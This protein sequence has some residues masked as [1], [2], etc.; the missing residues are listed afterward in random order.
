MVGDEGMAWL[1]DV[2]EQ[3]D[4]ATKRLLTTVGGLTDRRVGEPSLLPGWSRGHVLSHMA[5]AAGAH[6]N[7]LQ[8][9]QGRDVPAY[10]SQEARDQ[11]IEEGAG[12]TVAEHLAELERSAARF[13]SAVAE[14]P[15]E[16]WD[17]PVTI[18]HLPPFPASQVLL[19][20]L[21]ETELHHV[22]L[23]AGYRVSDWPAS[24]R[25]GELPEPMRA[26]AADRMAWQ[27]Q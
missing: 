3:I 15:G 19:R 12:R 11:A 22:D 9:A 21:V 25:P 6:W 16:A 24:F 4:G 27:A 26:Q 10:A 2:L 17:T 5:G 20:R 18:L 8:A 13:R 1:D 14:V 7:L 23:D